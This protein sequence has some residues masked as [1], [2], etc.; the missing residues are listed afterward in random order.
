MSVSRAFWT[1]RMNS[2]AWPAPLLTG[3]WTLLGLASA[4]GALAAAQLA[5]HAPPLLHAER[6]GRMNQRVEV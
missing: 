4:W 6:R 2:I 5:V 1:A 3:R